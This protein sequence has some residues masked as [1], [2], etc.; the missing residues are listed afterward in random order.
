MPSG[1]SEPGEPGESVEPGERESPAAV[2]VAERASR[3][4]RDLVL[5][6]LVLLVPIALLIGVYRVVHKGDEPLVVDAA[7]VIA[8]ARA[9]GDLPVTEPA[10]LDQRWRVLSARYV[11]GDGAAVLRLGYLSPSGAGF[12]IVQSDRPAD[13]LLAEE[14][15]ASARPLGGERLGD[16]DW[17]RYRGRPGERALVLLEPKR[18]VLVVGAGSDAELA[19]LAS[20]LT[21]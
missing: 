12:Q 13:A 18:T 17:Q 14:L 4:P 9:A 10:G 3:R 6:L 19:A 5:S 2:P 20:A 8:E 15:T 11:G 21:R 1:S 7:P 16:R